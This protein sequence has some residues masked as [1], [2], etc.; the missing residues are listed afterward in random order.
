M[1][2]MLRGAPL[3][4]CTALVAI[5]CAPGGAR[6]AEP[7]TLESGAI[8][9]R[10][11]PDPFRIEFRDRSSGRVLRT[12]AGGPLPTLGDLHARYGAPGYSFDLRIPIL[13]NAYLGYYIGLNVE[14]LWFHGTRVL[15]ST[16]EGSDLVLD[17]ATNDPL[18]HRLSVRLTPTSE[19]AITVDSRIAPGSGPLAGLASVSGAAFEAEAGERFLG[20]GERSNA[21]D[22]TGN[23]VFSWAEEG[24]FSSGVGEALLR[25]LLPN[26]TFPT[27][28][29][30]TNFPIP[31]A[32]STRGFGVLI[33]QTQRSTFRLVSERADA[34]Q[35]EAE[36]GHFRFTVFA[37]PTPADVVRRYSGYAGRQPDPARWIFGPWFQPTGESRP[38][39]LA[40][41][42]RA[43]D[44]P[45]TVAQTYT[46]YLPCGAQVGRRD[47]ERE[48]TAGYHARGYKVTTYFNP[49][50]CAS[51][52]PLYGQA[53]ADGHLVRNGLGLPYLVTNP[54]T[55]DGLV[56][57]I[58]FT[59]PGGRALYARQLDEAIDD[60]FDGWMEDFGEYTPTDSVFANGKVGFE[61]HN[62]YP[63]EYHC[64][65]YDHTRARMG[66]DAAVFVRSG[67]HGVQP[68]A[69][70]VWG[71][72]PTEDW[73][74]ADGLCAA[75]HQM[76]ST[77]LSGVAYWGSD[78]GGF[79]ALVNPRTSD[80]LNTR[81]LQ[82]GA[83][84]GV[85]RT[86]AN[87]YSLLNNRPSRSQVWSPAVLPVWREYAKLR[88]Q[89]LPYIEAA[90]EAYQRSGMPLS[91]HLALAYP[92]DPAAVARS[93]EL[94]FGPDLLAAPVVT[95][96]DRER[97]LYLP[98]GEWIDLWQALRFDVPSGRF[99]NARV[100]ELITGGRE[101]T[102]P[103]PLDR[104]PLLAR[105]GAILPML[106]ADVDTLAP[107]GSG[108]S[109]VNLGERDGTRELLI[110]PR[111]VSKADLA[112]GEAIDSAE[113]PA[114][115]VT[116]TSTTTTKGKKTKAK[117][118]AGRGKRKAKR[119]KRK[120]RTVTTTT[121]T[122][123]PAAGSCGSRARPGASTTSRRRWGRSGSR[124]R[125]AR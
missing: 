68:C 30:A 52:A 4:L 74:C 119:R 82:L 19:G 111:G 16:H 55:A 109:L 79:H 47:A 85:M 97:S 26:F 83:V 124:S 24:P 107:E 86:Q 65:S 94:M 56:S 15:G 25:P 14:T 35:A 31:W 60:G 45:V 110:F 8:E 90:S 27:G 17:V 122:Q 118:K 6:A 93:D 12:L 34:W 38:F 75:L 106:P 10:V 36:A 3:A 102:V 92:S 32:V 123:L 71:G 59:N 76:L 7:V 120:R 66:R 62:R 77:G 96:G 42:F 117:K 67:F 121:A 84:S 95:P 116:S 20:F 9:A 101:I 64:A 78:I 23:Q 98:G 115:T 91:R 21:A 5:A 58:D 39:E 29:T 72:D 48:R 114:E 11:D 2:E 28:P 108:D 41:R 57:E 70:I 80:E 50:I 113:L 51:Y 63:V 37:G 44:V 112:G 1:R 49:H 13:N 18:G 103:A 100:P 40:E 43:D 53:A 125:R 104:L 99:L 61:M 81:W 89:L 105:A 33:D 69:R 54:F 88:T 46:H 87:G 73:S 22:Q